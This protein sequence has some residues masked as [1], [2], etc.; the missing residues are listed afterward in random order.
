VRNTTH[1]S[2]ITHTHIHTHDETLTCWLLHTS[3]TFHTIVVTHTGSVGLVILGSIQQRYPPGVPYKLTLPTD[4]A[5]RSVSC[6][7]TQRTSLFTR[8]CAPRSH[9][10]LQHTT[11]CYWVQ[12][13]SSTHQHMLLTPCAPHNSVPLT[14]MDI[15][16]LQSHHR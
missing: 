16:R 11:Q 15:P 7:N 4:Q 3:Y 1:H 2:T 13:L 8:R 10:T 12:C 14:A 9:E 5:F 6:R